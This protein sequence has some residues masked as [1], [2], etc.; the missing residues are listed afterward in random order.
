MSASVRP[1]GYVFRQGDVLLL[2]G[3]NAR[4]EAFTR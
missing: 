1:P 3:A 2:A 4:V